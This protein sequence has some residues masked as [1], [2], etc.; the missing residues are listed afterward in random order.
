MR[1]QRLA[2]TRLHADERDRQL[3]CGRRRRCRAARVNKL[4]E[5]RVHNSSSNN[6]LAERETQIR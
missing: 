3:S 1:E 5:D 2:L 4:R 6:S